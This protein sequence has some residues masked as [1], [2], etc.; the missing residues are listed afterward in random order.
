MSHGTGTDSWSMDRS[1]N[2][3]AAPVTF[4]SLPEL[5]QKSN[6]VELLK[7]INMVKRRLSSSLADG[8]EGFASS[9][10]IDLTATAVATVVVPARPGMFFVSTG[11]RFRHVATSGVAATDPVLQCGNNGTADNVV[12]A[13]AAP[14]AVS[15]A[16][17]APFSS[18]LTLA[19]NL[20]LVDMATPILAAV[21]TAATGVA[22]VW[23]GV[24]E[25][26]GYYVNP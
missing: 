8:P 6:K 23:Q 19:T 3:K 5:T 18:P 26:T 13:A 10:I 12:P 2:R 11:A 9:G 24:V 15:F 20:T 7:L 4:I 14:T 21:T 1:C 22:L 17:G 25:I 16:T